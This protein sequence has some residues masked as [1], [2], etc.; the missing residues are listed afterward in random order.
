MNSNKQKRIA[1]NAI[2][3]YI[4]LGIQL[5]IGFYTSR[6]ILEVLGIED[7]GIYNIVGGFVLLFTFLQGSLTQGTQRFLTFELGKRNQ[8]N[9]RNVFCTSMNIY[10]IFGVLIVILLCLIGFFWFDDFLNIPRTRLETAKVVYFLSV[11]TLFFQLISTPY[12]ALIIAHEDIKSFAYIDLIY[13]ILNLL[14]ILF[15]K[16]IS[17]SNSLL[18]YSIL[19]TG[20]SI[21]IRFVYSSFCK[22]RYKE[23]VYR[24]YWDKKLF[25]EIV[26]FSGWITLSSLSEL[27]RKQGINLL[28]NNVFGVVANAALAVANQVNGFIN[29]FASNLQTAYVPQLVKSY[30]EDN[31][32]QT[33]S[34]IYTGAKMC[35][36]LLIFFSVPLMIE[37]DFILS[38]WL[39]EVPSYANIL[40][41]LILLETI[42]RSMTYSMN[43]VI[44]ATGK[45]R[46]Y[47]IVLNIIQII[48]FVFCVVFTY[49]Y[50][51]VVT[52]FIV[53]II[54]AICTNCYMIYYCSKVIGISIKDYVIHVCINCFLML[55]LSLTFS[56]IVFCNF[57]EGFYRLILV[58]LAS[59]LVIVL[60][61]FTFVLSCKEKQ[62]I[63]KLLRRK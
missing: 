31:L 28:L 7:Y 57:S 18:I 27:L 35:C 63:L 54:S 48:L 26:S 34:L 9:V 22:K 59:S 40:L 33:R 61:L 16:Y 51:N 60:C 58:C 6:L 62:L 20:I 17:V 37:V 41:Q 24:F 30:A 42:M 23:A 49:V 53:L 47:E 45:I 43:S 3:L 29:R 5:I 11:C 13:T 15:L 4:R 19:V 55:L 50:E 21:L 12:N 44:R 39:K 38:F 25:Y 14:S 36:I 52:P 10:F 32:K 46:N 2:A 1:Q 8:E 56:Y